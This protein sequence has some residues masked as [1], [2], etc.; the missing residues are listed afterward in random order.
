MKKF[1]ELSRFRGWL[2]LKRIC[3]MAAVMMAVAGVSAGIAAQ[4]QQVTVPDLNG[5]TVA[6]AAAQLNAAGLALGREIVV[7]VDGRTPDVV[8]GQSV[9]AGQSAA[10]GSEVDVEIARSANIRLVYDDNDLTLINLTHAVLRLG[11]LSF[12]TVESTQSAAFNA[13][14]WSDIVR[15]RQCTQVWSVGR[16]G[17]KSL[18]ECEYIQNWLTTNNRGEHFWTA[19]SGARTF[20]VLQNGVE[21]AVCDAAPTNSQDRPLTCELYI[22]ADAQGDDVPFIYIAYTR[23]TLAVINISPDKW[24]RINDTVLVNGLENPDPF[25]REFKINNALFG[26]PEI[27]ARINRLAPNQCVVFATDAVTEPAGLQD[28]AMI[29]TYTVQASQAWWSANFEVQ[30]QDGKR[31]LCNAALNDRMTVC[32]MPR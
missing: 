5:L 20:R 32:I 17:P 26:R 2:M 3:K 4:P 6:Q 10:A 8:S 22:A 21:R 24:M 28:C 16:S 15:P 31:R 23:D 14:R 11:G 1:S 18:P 12:E 9:A 13:G 27:V 25:G 7:P 29:V 19:A 30:G